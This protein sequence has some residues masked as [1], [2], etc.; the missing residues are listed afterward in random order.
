MAPYEE[1]AGDS[2]KKQ[3]QGGAV[4]SCDRSG[5]RGGRWDKTHT[6]EERQRLIITND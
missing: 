2:G 1:A 5:V 4:L 3:A 6:V